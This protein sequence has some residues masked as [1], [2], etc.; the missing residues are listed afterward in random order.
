MTFEELYNRLLKNSVGGRLSEE[1]NLVRQEGYDPH[2]LSCLLDPGRHPL[3]LRTARCGCSDEQKHAC[4]N[5]CPF[6]ALILNGDGD[7]D[8]DSLGCVD[9]DAC[10]N[11]CKAKK[12]V[13]NR[14]FGSSQKAIQVAFKDAQK[15]YNQILSGQ[16]VDLSD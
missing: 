14:Y 5:A 12:L 13:E 9:C 7:I 16:T 10:I 11:H 3:V 8:V 6:D 2:Q 1:L 4:Q 15:K